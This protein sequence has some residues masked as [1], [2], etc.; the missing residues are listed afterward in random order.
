MAG[1]KKVEKEAE[2][3]YFFRN[4]LVQD[5]GVSEFPFEINGSYKMYKKLNLNICR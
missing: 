2:N 5:V 1:K 3:G 4:L